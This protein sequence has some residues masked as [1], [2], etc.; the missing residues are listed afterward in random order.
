MEK[1]VVLNAVLGAMNGAFDRKDGED[2]F[3]GLNTTLA[4]LDAETASRRP[5]PNRSSIAA[6]V[7]HLLYSLEVVNARFAGE[8]LEPHWEA[9]W[10]QP[11]VT[12]EEWETLRSRLDEQ[13]RA[14]EAKISGRTELSQRFLEAAIS[15]LVHLG[16]HVGAIR[17]L[18]LAVR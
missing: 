10:Q 12:T 9:A 2:W 8:P 4:T 7:R 11:T 1:D 14:L 13:R 5:A 3:D 17:Q 16:Y 15:S 6:H 18:L